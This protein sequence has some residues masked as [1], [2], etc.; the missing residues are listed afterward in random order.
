M[1]SAAADLNALLSRLQIDRL[2]VVLIDDPACPQAPQLMEKAGATAAHSRDP[3]LENLPVWTFGNVLAC[4][5][6]S[7]E[8]ANEPQLGNLLKRTYGEYSRIAYVDAAL[9]LCNPAS[10]DDAAARMAYLLG[11]GFPADRV[12][13]LISHDFADSSQETGSAPAMARYESE[14]KRLLDAL[15]T[16]GVAPKANFSFSLNSGYNTRNL[17]PW[18]AAN[19]PAERRTLNLR[20]YERKGCKFA[21]GQPGG[22]PGSGKLLNVPAST[23]LGTF[24]I[25]GERLYAIAENSLIEFQPAQKPGKISKLPENPLLTSAGMEELYYNPDWYILQQAGGKIFYRGRNLH[26]FLGDE[27]WLT[28]PFTT[29]SK[30]PCYRVCHKAGTWLVY[31]LQLFWPGEIRIHAGEE[32]GNLTEVRLPGRNIS[33]MCEIMACG[34]LF[35]LAVG[36]GSETKVLVSHNGLEWQESGRVYGELLGAFRVGDRMVLRCKAASYLW[37]AS[38]GSIRE[39]HWPQIWGAEPW[40]VES[41]PSSPLIAAI[42]QAEIALCSAS[43]PG[44][45]V[46]FGTDRQPGKVEVN[47]RLLA[48]GFRGSSGLQYCWLEDMQKVASIARH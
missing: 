12:L 18:L 41:F 9:V 30:D 14:A 17:L 44:K 45:P 8:P 37:D 31:H 6:I 36:E 1:P 7:G 26:V 43:T 4:W 20:R 19:L 38:V 13:A 42:G 46:I 39:W 27:G 34:D 21:E 15:A 33:R 24:A 22:Q 10:A 32:L 3:D 16:R 48:L 28:L 5:H 25:S 23:S 40:R 11:L 35:C 29:R 2:D 47:G